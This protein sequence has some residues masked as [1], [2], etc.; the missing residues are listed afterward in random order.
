M[1]K[2]TIVDWGGPTIRAWCSLGST[3]T[4]RIGEDGIGVTPNP[5]RCSAL[6][7]LHEIRSS[8]LLHSLV[9]SLSNSSLGSATRS[10]ERGLTCLEQ[11]S[12]LK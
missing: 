5:T 3:Q 9:T 11:S 6:R 2:G 1:G 4:K 7:V 8:S 12:Q 10:E